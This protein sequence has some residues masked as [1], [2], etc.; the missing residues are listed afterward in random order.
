M[1]AGL[2]DARVNAETAYTVSK[3]NA[4]ATGSGGS[5]Q[6][7]AAAW[8]AA[9]KQYAI[10]ERQALAAQANSVASQSPWAAILA[11]KLTAESQNNDVANQYDRSILQA[12]TIA[13]RERGT[14]N[15]EKTDRLAAIDQSKAKSGSDSQH[16]ATLAADYAAQID[17]LFSELDEAGLGGLR[18]NG[19][20]APQPIIQSPETDEDEFAIEQAAN[21]RFYEPFAYASEGAGMNN[22]QWEHDPAG[23]LSVGSPVW[24]ATAGG[25]QS[26]DGRQNPGGFF[27][28]QW[29]Q[30]SNTAH[31]VEFAGF[32]VA[33]QVHL[34][35]PGELFEENAAWDRSLF[36]K[37]DTF[38][39]AEQNKASFQFSSY[40]D[41]EEV[42]DF[43]LKIDA[44]QDARYLNNGGIFELIRAT[45]PSLPPRLNDSITKP[46]YV[47]SEAGANGNSFIEIVGIESGRK[48]IESDVRMLLTQAN[49]AAGDRFAVYGLQASQQSALERN[50][51]QVAFDASNSESEFELQNS[52]EVPKNMSD[53]L[54][55]LEVLVEEDAKNIDVA[56]DAS[57]VS[58]N[59]WNWLGEN[60]DDFSSQRYRDQPGQPNEQKAFVVEL[61]REEL[62]RANLF[63]YA[64]IRLADLQEKIA[65][66]EEYV[67]G[68]RNIHPR[69]SKQRSDY[70][71]ELKD[72]KL[73]ERPLTLDREMLLQGLIDDFSELEVPSSFIQNNN[74]EIFVTWTEGG[75]GVNALVAFAIHLRKN[76]RLT[77]TGGGLIPVVGPEVAF[78]A[79]GANVLRSLLAGATLRAAAKA[80][81]SGAAEE[82]ASEITGL[83]VVNP[84]ELGRLVNGLPNSIPNA[85]K[86][87]AVWDELPLL[88][89]AR[90]AGE[91]A[92]GSFVGKRIAAS[93]SVPEGVYK[94]VVDKD[95]K[96][97]LAQVTEDIPHSALVPK[98]DG[99]RGAGYVA[100]KNG[101]A[102]VNGRSGHYMAETPLLGEKAR[103]YDRAIRQT[104]KD[105]G[106]DVIDNHV[107]LG[108]RVIRPPQ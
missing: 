17:A 32:E 38:R 44:L 45:S 101:R 98:G 95:G 83:P 3:A 25:F 99:V 47:S 28:N 75:I 74:G 84:K 37:E 23:V 39:T 68:R 66:T 43:V 72:L 46:I 60:S 82:I 52:S 97:W 85:P 48:A 14:A 50:A 86:G 91:A 27:T 16:N 20:S 9:Y 56:A 103:L 67:S 88:R 69:S 40:W 93:N 55:G 104:F 8:A 53:S 29:W 58:D 80:G 21:R 7:S 51:R 73:R 70:I 94:F 106:I 108:G 15:D 41:N 30:L 92:A 64:A 13:D 100:V 90:G 35:N 4:Y 5:A 77:T 11:D 36:F 18:S 65:I 71:E 61:L 22:G 81:F 31:W 102:N 89:N 59:R 76:P 10:A 107:G 54:D 6:G 24:N 33:S 62:R 78:G 49:S 96:I 79:F 57:V 105:H 2:A 63:L 26:V 87:L 19:Y 12:T 34:I 1:D 42:R